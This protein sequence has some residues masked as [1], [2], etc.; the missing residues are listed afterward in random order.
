MPNKQAESEAGSD[1]EKSATKSPDTDHQAYPPRA[2]N[3]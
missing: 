2:V 1:A 3:G